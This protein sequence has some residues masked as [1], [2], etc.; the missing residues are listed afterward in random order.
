MTSKNALFHFLD[1]S[2]KGA[3]NFGDGSFITCEG[4][5]DIH[6]NCKNGDKFVIPT[7][8]YFMS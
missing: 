2:K 7:V 6:I 5:G 8:L 3:M 1:D 4:K